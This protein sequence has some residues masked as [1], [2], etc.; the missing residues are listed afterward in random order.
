MGKHAK[1][2]GSSRD[3]AARP[4]TAGAGSASSAPR[5]VD[6]ASATTASASAARNPDP[7]ARY[8]DESRAKRRRNKTILLGALAVVGVLA[9]AATAWAWQF[10]HAVGEDMSDQV[11]VDKRILAALTPKPV[12]RQVKKQEPFTILLLGVDHLGVKGDTRSDTIMLGRVD[13]QAKKLWLMSIPRDTRAEIPGHG[14]QKINQAYTLG[15][16]ALAIKTVTKLTGVQPDHYVEVDIA[17]FKAIV[18]V[19]GGVWVNVRERINDPKAAGAN[20]NRAGATI[21]KGY[22]KL[23]ANQAIVYVRSR[24]YA[25]ADF[26][27]MRHQQ[28]FLKAVAKQASKPAMFPRLPKLVRTMGRYVNTDLTLA[29]MVSLAGAMRG[30]KTADFQTATVP[31]EWR[32]PYV[33]PDEKQ[34]AVLV[35]RMKAGQEFKPST[36]PKDVVPA[37]YTVAV[38]NGSGMGGLAATAAGLLRPLGWK[39]GEV[40]NAK[41]QDYAKTLIVY[42]PENVGVAKRVQ[43]ALRRGKLL[44]DPNHTYSFTGDVL[45]VVGRDWRSS[46]ATPTA[47]KP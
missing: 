30:L 24:A 42:A 27:R 23:D 46:A 8:R 4:T 29:Q 20:A 31:G 5:S 17:G 14:V 36:D 26:G 15:G 47:S 3:R 28:D 34:M 22:Q 25:D 35:A 13:P 37:N 1:K 2:R 32:S 7:A 18:K 33:W 10:T 19:M 44:E 9:L 39:V 43:S 16:P 40:G 21:E 11:R 41:R 38:R 45:V 12:K 6:R